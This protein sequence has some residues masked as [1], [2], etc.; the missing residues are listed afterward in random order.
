M[1]TL[2][3]I[4]NIFT[5]ILVAFVVLAAVALV[6]VRLIHL[7]P[8]AVLSGSM[9]PTYKT[10]SVVYVK[11]VDYRTLKVGDPIT[12]LLDQNTVA[13]HRIVE[14]LPDEEDA[15]AVRYRTK[16]DN[17]ETVDGGLVH[18]RNVIGMPIFSVP[19]LGYAANYIQSPPGSFVVLALCLLLVL[20]VILPELFPG[21]HKKKKKRKKKN[22]MKNRRKEAADEAD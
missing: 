7:E 12:F 10:G 11:K 16:G 22:T 9:E 6:G 5:W 14:I 4:W 20:L 1:R 17:N 18:C 2:R 13:T 21:R 19:Y 8:Y 15:G 3:K